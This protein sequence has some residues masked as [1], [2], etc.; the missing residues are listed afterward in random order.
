MSV[1][2]TQILARVESHVADTARWARF[3]PAV[4]TAVAA[5]GRSAGKR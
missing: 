4:A 1:L 3:L 5:S 2:A